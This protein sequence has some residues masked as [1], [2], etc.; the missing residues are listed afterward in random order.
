MRT[1]ENGYGCG[2]YAVANALKIDSFI[3]DERLDS[4]KNGVSIGKLNKYLLDDGMG[5]FIDVLYCDTLRSKLPEDWCRLYSQYSNKLFPILIQC[6][7]SSKFHLIAATL[8]DEA[9]V[10]ILYDSLSKEP[11]KCMLSEVNGMYDEVV[12]LY[13]FNYIDTTEYFTY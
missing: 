12:G 3:T 2:L 4:S 8:S 7:V 1:Q 10:I 13:S 5:I 11:I 9:G 6:V